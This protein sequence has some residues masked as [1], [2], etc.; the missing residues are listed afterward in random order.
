[1]AIV[2]LEEGIRLHTSI[3][4]CAP[5]ALAVGLPVEVVFTPV[6]DEV[7]LPRFRLRE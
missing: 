1:V 3:V 7:T 4:D 2:E 5:E 6:N